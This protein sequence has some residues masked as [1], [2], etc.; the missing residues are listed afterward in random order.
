MRRTPVIPNGDHASN[1][2]R[3]ANVALGGV[4]LINVGNVSPGASHSLDHAVDTLCRIGRPCR[5]HYWIRNNRVQWRL[6]SEAL[7]QGDLVGVRID[8]EEPTGF[9]RQQRIYAKRTEPYHGDVHAGTD[10]T[11]LRFFKIL[12]QSSFGAGASFRVV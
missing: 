2:G 5:S 10:A 7:R 1:A 11:D 6:I 12:R 8:R 4:G 3:G 9:V